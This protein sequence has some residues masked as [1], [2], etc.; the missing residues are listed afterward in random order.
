MQTKNLQTLRTLRNQEKAIKAQIDK[1]SGDAT[2]EAVAILAKQGKDRG[3]FE[4]PGV[5][6]FQLQRTDVFD[7]SDYNK[8]KS[9]EAVNWRA[10]AK[11]KL[12]LQNLVKACT[13][14]MAGFLK[15]FTE[16][17]PDKQPDEIKLTV[18]VVD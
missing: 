1:I 9:E 12:R 8:Y 10:K 3:E 6:T 14:T 5:G 17:N 16:L 13:T 18:K 2:K 11:E 15:T 7:L 4:V